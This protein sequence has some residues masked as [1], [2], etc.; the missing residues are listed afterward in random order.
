MPEVKAFFTSSIATKK[1]TTI[2]KREFYSFE[3]DLI[4]SKIG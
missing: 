1:L 4:F 2:K 3:Y